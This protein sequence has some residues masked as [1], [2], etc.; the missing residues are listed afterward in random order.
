VNAEQPASPAQPSP[1]ADWTDHRVATWGRAICQ[2]RALPTH[3]QVAAEEA[4]VLEEWARRWRRRGPTDPFGQVELGLVEE[5]AGE[6]RRLAGRGHTERD[7]GGDR[8]R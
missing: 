7:Q 6:L 8:E 4:G 1:L 5:L 3:P 2:Q